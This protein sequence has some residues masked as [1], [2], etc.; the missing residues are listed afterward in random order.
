MI[1][2]KEE[3]LK[4]NLDYFNHDVKNYPHLHDINE[5]YRLLN[6]ITN[7]Y[8]DILILDIGTAMGHSCL[9]LAQNKKNKIITYDILERN[10]SFFNFYNNVIFKKMD[11]NEETS[12][13]IK[14]AKIIFLDVDPHD[15]IQEKKF[16][17]MLENIDFKGYLIC[18]DINLNS[19]MK[20]WWD[21]IEYEKYDLTEIGHW[22][23]TGLI[24]YNND[25]N[26]SL[27]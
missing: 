24:N 2:K 17:D 12:E 22:S 13:N 3:I 6:Y 27:I 14:L 8:E 16:T 25:G 26:F 20:Y 18:D 5:H 11:A 21:S 15:G 7:L 9:S 1:L 4:I 19:G 10:H 23:G